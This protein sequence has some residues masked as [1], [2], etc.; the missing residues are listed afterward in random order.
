M[1]QGLTPCRSTVIMLSFFGHLHPVLV[2]LPIGILLLACLFMW[3]SRKDRH[4]NLQP[5]INVILFWGMISA[6]ASCI[7][8]YLLSQS[9]EYDKGLV[10]LHQWMGISVAIISAIT[11]YLRKTS[12]LVKWQWIMGTLLLLLLFITGHLGGSL[13]HGTDYLTQPLKEMLGTDTPVVTKRKPIA[14][15]QEAVIYT[16][17]IQPVFQNK[18]YSCHGAEKQKG[19]FRM[20]QPELL[21]KGG[22]D[23]AVIAAGKPAESELIKRISLPRN[24]E[25]HMAPKEKPQLTEQETALLDWWIGG[26]AD[27]TKKVKDVLQ[28]E[29]IKTMLMT[30]QGVHDE[31]IKLPGDV[32]LEETTPANEG[33][34]N[35]LRNMGVI[36]IP[37]AQN[38]NYVDANFVTALNTTDSTISLLLTL[39]KQL[40]WLKLGHTNLTD[41][42]LKYIGQCTNLTRLQLDHTLITD[43]GLAQLKTLTH[44]QTL[45]LTGTDVTTDGVKS[46]KNLQQLRSIYLYQTRV[47]RTEWSELKKIFPQLS[48]DSGG[49]T[50]PFLPT[51]TMIV[52]P[53]KTR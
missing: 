38:S 3:Q 48:I 41:T 25:H 18:C 33:A 34:V 39:K 10:S 11:Y 5:V 15:I 12:T 13:T 53:P 14:N 4:E 30:L 31:T 1:K 46:L 20:D 36:V 35:R 49:Y 43:K 27:F 44:L 17:I 16:D 28:S 2:H 7:T 19:K 37:V 9:G 51:D 24:D 29:K 8:G 32:P 45:N 21:M 40:I 52:K 50:V 47:D 26:G 6:I 42:T 23:G 22:K